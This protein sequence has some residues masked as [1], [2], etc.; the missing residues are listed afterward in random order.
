[1]LE[2]HFGQIWSSFLSSFWFTSKGRTP[3]PFQPASPPF[4][5]R[6]LNPTSGEPIQHHQS[7]QQL[8]GT[9]PHQLKIKWRGDDTELFISQ[10]LLCHPPP[11]NRPYQGTTNTAAPLTILQL[12]SQ[13]A[14]CL[15]Q[16]NQISQSEARSHHHFR[17]SVVLIIKLHSCINHSHFHHQIHSSL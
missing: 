16:F 2:G 3:S 4:T 7:S 11:G 6:T 12:S 1:M 17:V 9:T 15:G 10:V 8:S 13:A 14:Q 5:S